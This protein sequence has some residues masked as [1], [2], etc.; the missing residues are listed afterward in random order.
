MSEDVLHCA[1]ELQFDKKTGKKKYD[2]ITKGVIR[3]VEG[4]NV[5]SFSVNN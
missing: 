2:K 1:S 5:E 3:I 4:S